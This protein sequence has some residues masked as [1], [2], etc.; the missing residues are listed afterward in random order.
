MTELPNKQYSGYH[1]ATE[2]GNYPQMCGKRSKERN[3]HSS[4]QS[5][6]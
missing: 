5:Q 4:V 3:V 1:N 6:H 2:K